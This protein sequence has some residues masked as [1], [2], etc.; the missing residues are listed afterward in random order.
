MQMAEAVK[1]KWRQ[2]ERKLGGWFPTKT[3]QGP[4]EFMRVKNSA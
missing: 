2:E 1:F 3:G 4:D